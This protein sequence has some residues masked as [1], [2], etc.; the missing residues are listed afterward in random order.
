MVG[1]PK[2]YYDRYPHQL[3]GGEKQRIGI[4]RA[5]APGPTFIVCDEPVSALD[6]SVQ[7]TI[8]NLLA[9]L[10]D[11]LGLSYLFISHDLAVVAHLADRIA[12]MYAGRLCEVGPTAAVLSPPYHPYTERLL[13]AVAPADRGATSGA[14]IA[15]SRDPPGE[16]PRAGCPFHTRCP[17]KLGAVCETVEPPLVV[18]GP[19]HGISCHIPLAALRSVS[20]VLPSARESHT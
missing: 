4:A 7:A 16:P 14:G 19:G 9:D 13:A 3:S 20:P 6:V 10:R 12:V 5:L 2:H 17:R 11:E 18:A 1:L 8:L 15:L